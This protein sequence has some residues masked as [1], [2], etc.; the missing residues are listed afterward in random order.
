VTATKAS[1]LTNDLAAFVGA[2]GAVHLAGGT[3]T[4][5]PA[6]LAGDAAYWQPFLSAA[7]GTSEFGLSGSDA[8][9]AL[10]PPL[11]FAG[12]VGTGVTNLDWYMG[13]G[14]AVGATASAAVWDSQRVLVATWSVPPVH[15][16]SPTLVGTNFSFRFSTANYRRYTIEQ[17]T[18]LATTN[19]VPCTNLIGNG[20]PY[21]F[22]TPLSSSPQTFFR[23][24]EH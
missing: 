9:I 1:T 24:R 22:P 16:Q 23:V 21:V 7:T 10:A 4:F 19:W 17:N 14:V 20:S 13:Q 15:I 6:T 5:S 3:G 11:S 12:P 8:W 18:N 2:D